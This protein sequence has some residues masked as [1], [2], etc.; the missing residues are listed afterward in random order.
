MDRFELSQIQPL[1][2]GI[3]DTC[4]NNYTGKVRLADRFGIPVS[5]VDAIRKSPAYQRQVKHLLVTT[6]SPAEFQR[7]Q[8][9]YND[10]AVR[11]GRYMGI[12]PIIAERLISEASQELLSPVSLV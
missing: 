9:S 4:W 8:N 5:A 7:W 3:A 1:I 2:E 12:E 11:F 10:M 6:R